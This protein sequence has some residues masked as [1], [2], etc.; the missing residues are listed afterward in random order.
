MFEASGRVSAR[1]ALR[2]RGRQ[3]SEKVR[4]QPGIIHL[5]GALAGAAPSFPSNTAA[6]AGSFTSGAPIILALAACRYKPRRPPESPLESGFHASSPAVRPS[7]MAIFRSQSPIQSHISLK[8]DR[9]PVTSLSQIEINLPAIDRN[10]ALIRRVCSSRGRPVGLCAVLKAD[11]Y[12][13]GSELLAPR[14]EQA[15][16]EMFAV[17]SAA[18]AEDL[19]RATNASPV[20]ILA[21]V[22]ELPSAGPLAEAIAD[23]RAHFAVHDLDQA[24]ALAGAASERNATL[25]VHLEANTGMNRG[26][27]A[28]TRATRVLEFIHACDALRL[29]GAYTHFSSASRDQERTSDQSRRFKE[30]LRECDALI[31]ADAMLHEAATYATFRSSDFHAGMVRIGLG[32]VGIA[33]EQLADPEN[34]ELAPY[35]DELQPAL[36]WTSSIVHTSW[37]EPGESVGYGAKWTAQRRTRLGLVPVGY[38]DGYPVSLTNKAKIGVMLPD[39]A[40]SFVPGVGRVSMDQITIDLTDLPE[41]TVGVGCVVE[42]VGDDRDAPNHL[43][44]LARLSGRITH[45]FLTGIS[46]RVPRVIAGSPESQRRSAESSRL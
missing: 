16:V 33:R 45:E 27:V 6:F 1:N 37:I 38:A 24:E 11:A 4:D 41:E 10:V 25:P 36:R 14:L 8:N 5:S 17:F 12:G 19:L 31:P 39:G 18:Q 34:C 26:G 35:A 20:L 30:W 46:P 22:F 3:P 42:I 29:T 21:P 23:S 32:L 43:P 2:S 7:E 44:H 9:S 13:L 28:T 15:G 40:R